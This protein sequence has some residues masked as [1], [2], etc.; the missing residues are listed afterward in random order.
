MRGALT[1]LAILLGG[2]AADAS[3]GRWERSPLSL[4]AGAGVP[5]EPLTAAATAWSGLG[6]ELLPPVAGDGCD[7]DVEL[8]VPS[9]GA[10]SAWRWRNSRGEIRFVVITLHE[11]LV[12]GDAEAE[13]DVLDLQSVLTHELGHALGLE[14]ES[15]PGAVMR[16]SIEPGEV[17]RVL[18]AADA[19]AALALYP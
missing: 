2:C 15:D 12:F 14:H 9:K 11:G 17:R 19:E 4:C 3:T 10:A 8:G 1:A 7:I 16:R 13:P 5:L 6:P 18:T